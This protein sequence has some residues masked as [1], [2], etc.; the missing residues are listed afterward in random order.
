[1]DHGCNAYCTETLHCELVYTSERAT[2]GDIRQAL[3]VLRG[4][5]VDRAEPAPEAPPIEAA[6]GSA[7]IVTGVRPDGARAWLVYWQH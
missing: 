4:L 3:G 5:R 1:M 7:D 2:A 6:G